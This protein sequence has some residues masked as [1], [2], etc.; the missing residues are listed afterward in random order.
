MSCGEWI[1]IF[2]CEQVGRKQSKF[3]PATSIVTCRNRRKTTP[4]RIF[5]SFAVSM[6]TVCSVVKVVMWYGPDWDLTDCISAHCENHIPPEYL[7]YMTNSLTCGWPTH[8]MGV[9][10]S[11]QLQTPFRHHRAETGLRQCCSVSQL[12]CTAK[13]R[14]FFSV[15]HRTKL[16][17][18]GCLLN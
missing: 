14:L 5:Q 4:S 12:L 15:P 16:N 13:I 6:G 7:F 8:L 3:S 10:V 1:N 2:A 17:N 11:S 9:A 18:V